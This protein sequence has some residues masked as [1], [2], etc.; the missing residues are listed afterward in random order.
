MQNVFS[1]VI[2]SLQ[3]KCTTQASIASQVQVVYQHPFVNWLLFVGIVGVQVK[4]QYLPLV[5]TVHKVQAIAY[6][7]KSDATKVQV[8]VV[9]Q[10]PLVSWLLL[11][12]MVGFPVKSQY[13]QLV[14]TV[15]RV[16][17]LA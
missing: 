16:Q 6:G 17:V 5:A 7:V 15:H 12:G 14:A 1:Q 3:A 2:V 11:V 9:Y 8:Q 13:F 4:S 10:Q